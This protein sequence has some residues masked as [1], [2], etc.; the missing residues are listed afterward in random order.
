MAKTIIG[1]YRQ[2]N[3]RTRIIGWKEVRYDS[4]EVLETM[5][6]I[7]PCSKFV[8]NY[9]KNLTAHRA[10]ILRKWK[11]TKLSMDYLT[12]RLRLLTV[13]FA[14]R[15]PSAVYE[16][17]LR[18]FTVKKYTKLLRWIGVENCEFK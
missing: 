7:F 14:G 13:D 2:H 12:K 16:M 6:K 8:I 10:S 3:N 11:W 1:N 5:R 4:L 17:P 18:D 15:Y 9:R